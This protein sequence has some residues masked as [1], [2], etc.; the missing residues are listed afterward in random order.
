V[1]YLDY[2]PHHATLWYS[3]GPIC[4]ST[5]VAA[6]SAEGARADA[7]AAIA[8]VAMALAASLQTANEVYATTDEEQRDILDEQMRS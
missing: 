4:G 5:N 3:H 7:G 6:S 1:D 8:Q 2:F